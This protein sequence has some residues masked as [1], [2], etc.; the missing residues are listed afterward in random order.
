MVWDVYGA[1]MFRGVCKASSLPLT[2]R[3]VTTYGFRSPEC[4]QSFTD[5][6]YDFGSALYRGQSLLG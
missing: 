6:R 1:L 5:T 4:L 2:P 3:N